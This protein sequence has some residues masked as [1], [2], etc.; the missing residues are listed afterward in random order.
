MSA[1]EYLFRTVALMTIGVVVANV[2]M[3]TKMLAGID[4]PAQFLCRASNLPDCCMVSLFSCLISPTA[5]KSLLSEFY[6]KGEVGEKETILTILMSTFPVVLGESLFRVQAPIAIVL[7]GPALGSTYVLLN[8]F[9]SFIQ[10]FTALLYSKTSPPSTRNP[11]EAT[12]RKDG[13]KDGYKGPKG[14]EVLRGAAEENDRFKIKR[15]IVMKGIERSIPTL[16]RTLPI[17]AGT[18]ILMDVIMSIGGMGL[19]GSIFDPPL[20][21][22]GLPGDCAAPLAMQ[23]VHFSAGYASVASLLAS[24]AITE[25]QALITLLIGSMAVITSIYL[26]Y[27]LSMYVSLFGKFGTKIAAIGY[28]S[29]MTAKIVTIFLVMTFF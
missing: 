27:S 12:R 28:L 6:R 7:L 10:S 23:F 20:R 14:A 29:S 15:K 3:E 21:L 13:Y 1:L 11:A 2:V 5:G 8:L 16:K 9:S 25:K 4:R 17:V 24:G 26:K 22:L 18:M 19:L